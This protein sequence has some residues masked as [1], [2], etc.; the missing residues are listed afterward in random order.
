MSELD[1]ALTDIVNIRSRLAASAMFQGFG[2]VV[3]A[4]TGGLALAM[5]ALQ[6]A[7]PEL[8][9]ADLMAYLKYWI[10][11]AVVSAGLI[12]LEMYNRSH[13]I[14]GGLADAMI[15]NAV[16]NFLPAGIAGAV[17]TAVIMQF[18]PDAMWILPGLWQ[19]LIALGIFAAV[20]SLPRA[21]NL[22]GGWYLLS[23]TVVLILAAEGR[24]IPQRLDPWM[25]G[26]PFAIGQFLMAA[27]LWQ[28]SLEGEHDEI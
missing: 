13:R 15:V 28:A 20:R 5:A 16:E 27:I 4:T 7:W 9:A 18:A 10:A 12:G 6:S 24:G 26:L 22:A 8:F 2:P 25:M 14:H 3:I 11:T 23:G 1:K 17:I 21:I 19:V